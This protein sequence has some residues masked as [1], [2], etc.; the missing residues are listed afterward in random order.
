MS[1]RLDGTSGT[2]GFELSDIDQRILELNQ[3]GYSL[4]NISKVLT[5]N[6]I[7]L[8]K[9]G[10]AR[11]LRELRQDADNG[12][13]INFKCTSQKP[14]EQQKWYRVALR[15]KQWLPEYQ[16]IWGTKPSPRTAFYAMQDEHL[17]TRT[18][19][20]MFGKVMV[21]AR[22]GWVDAEGNLLYP[23]LDID[24][25]SD[26][27]DRSK[28]AGYYDN[29]EPVG[30]ARPP[31][32][33]EYINDLIRQVEEAEEDLETARQRALEDLEA[34]KEEL[35][36]APNNYYGL[37]SSG[38]RGGLWYGQPEYLEP[39]QEKVDLISNFEELLKDWG[40]KIRGNGGYP[41]LMFLNLCCVELKALIDRT[42]LEPEHIH[43]KY[44]GDF[45]PSGRNIDYYIQKRLK[46]LGISG[47]GFQRIAVTPE[48]ID[49][50]KLPLM[51]IEKDPNK[52]TANP[53]LA[54]F[55]RLYGNKATH[56]NAFMIP[57][58]KEPF[59][60]VLDD[61]IR[62]HWD[63]DIYQEMIDEYEGEPEQIENLR[64]V[65]ENMRNKILDAGY[66]VEPLDSDT[67]SED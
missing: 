50:Y 58:L 30:P 9:S 65:R 25:F 64:N 11:H 43:I 17:I 60:K 7:I 27:K 32:P 63:P 56:L 45:D 49:K 39:W 53:N 1:N 26:E 40:I 21:E 48:Q 57:R 66:E 35:F 15:V 59:K 54:E 18:D 23:K 16:R 37:G 34:A 44:C 14:K 4:G 36:N 13:Q 62:P 31:D 12:V 10:V 28:S 5:A 46:Q 19:D 41:S 51:N 67:D 3:E 22:L 29:F 47:I 52:K 6:G 24:C 38:R 33:D 55:K 61:A 8:S 2:T 20:G 42:K